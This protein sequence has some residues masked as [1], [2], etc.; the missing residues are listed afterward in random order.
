MYWVL[1]HSSPACFGCYRADV[2]IRLVPEWG[3]QT[4]WRR[5][6]A[7]TT[8]RWRP[9]RRKRK[10]REKKEKDNKEEE[11]KPN[12]AMWQKV[13]D[14]LIAQNPDFEYVRV[15]N[16]LAAVHQKNASTSRATDKYE[17]DKKTGEITD[18]AL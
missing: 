15:Q 11:R 5:N 9:K 17:F 7:R 16:D 10:D 2:V 12:F 13:A 8:R 1:M 3:L 4:L 6:S 18:R 14:D